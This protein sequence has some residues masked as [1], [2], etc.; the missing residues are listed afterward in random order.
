[1]ERLANWTWQV[2]SGVRRWF[3]SLLGVPVV[4]ILLGA[5]LALLTAWLALWLDDV[6]TVVTVDVAQTVL[7][8]IG[9]AT[10]TLAG[11]VLTIATLSLQFGATTYAPRLVE[12]L[13]RDRLLRHTL[14]GAL[15][16]F[17]YSVVVILVVRTDHQIAATIAAVVALVGATGTVLLF[18][19]LL[20]RLTS[21]LR[22]GR[23]LSQVTAQALR[24]VDGAYPVE[25]GGEAEPALDN[26][27]EHTMV[28]WSG[29]P[30]AGVIWREGPAG[31]LVDIDLSSLESLARDRG[32]CVSLTVPIG[33]FLPS[34]EAVAVLTD[35]STGV[36]VDVDDDVGPMVRAAL[37]VGDER[38]VDADPAFPLRLLVD[39]ALRA[40]SPGVNDPT[41]AGQ[42]I[43]HIEQVVTELAG[44]RLGA[45]L[46]LVDDEVGVSL[47]A[48][49]WT[50]ILDLAWT[51]I[52]HFGSDPQTRQSLGLAL[53]RLYARVAP[54]R[55]G[56]VQQ[57]ADRL[58]F[59]L[60]RADGVIG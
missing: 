16:T 30:S 34:R 26:L 47:P 28:D 52:A 60:A 46:V 22:P 10:L 43:D 3:G 4:D 23:T 15:G 8:A 24:T 2:R 1:M 7:P 17:T 37:V 49:G 35:R 18:I 33:A 55:R 19:G 27:P 50:S 39:I 41:T 44:R 57:I 13:R 51:E 29:L 31:N 11:F 6:P 48:P 25:S 20:E 40:L 54:H 59:D 53:R 38:T 14:G 58:E 21:T 12:Q 32:L 36:P 5:A 45:R 56:A 9:S 42:A